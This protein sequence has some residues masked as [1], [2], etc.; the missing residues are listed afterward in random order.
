M[1][2][3]ILFG[4]PTHG[5]IGDAAIVVAEE[6]FIKDNL[7]DYEYISVLEEEETKENIEQFQKIIRD[8]DIILL[9]GGGNFG[10]KY[11]ELEE[12]RRMIITAFP[13]NKIILMPQ[14]IHFSDNENGKM[15][16]EKSKKI[17]GNHK[18]LTLVAREKVS[19]EIMKREFSN[20]N[21]IFTPDIVMYLNETEQRERKGALLAIRIDMEKVLTDEQIEQIK[22]IVSRNFE[23]VKRTDT[24]LGFENIKVTE[25]GVEGD[26]QILPEMRNKVVNDKLEEFRNA[27]LIITD[28][29]HGMILST[30]TSTPCIAFSN[31]NHKI[32]STFDWIK[33]QKYV[34]FL[35]DTN[36][37]EE[38]IKE[39][40]EYKNCVYNNEFALK[41]YQKILDV[42]NN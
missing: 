24:Y 30:I 11:I 9:H 2:K 7:S 32:K 6:K 12:K 17:Y 33:D 31:Y 39:L 36:M 40:K 38:T 1:K 4:V 21:V 29:M 37:L 22:E 28:R 18:N 27:E 26:T 34:K 35:E 5:N 23:S 16:L 10:D 13:N 15:E 42:I 19:L 25:D 14:T 20:N 3:V 8:E 41:E